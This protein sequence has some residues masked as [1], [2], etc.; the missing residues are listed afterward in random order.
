[1]NNFTFLKMK[2]V[3]TNHNLSQS[4][5]NMYHNTKLL[6]SK[7][8]DIVWSINISL[9]EMDEEC[10]YSV[11]VHSPLLFYLDSM[12][13]IDTRIDQARLKSRLSSL[14]DSKSI[15]D[16]INKSVNLIGKY[17]KKGK[18]YQNII[19]RAYIDVDEISMEFIAEELN[20]SRASFFR[21]KK[22]AINL[23]GSMLWGYITREYMKESEF[24]VD[25]LIMS[26]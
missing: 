9:D 8:R 12:V 4:K 11:H 2:Q 3:N 25:E 26:C 17:P 21:E 14:E 10:Q 15:I 5:E 22:K 16:L 19:L 20:M 24:T 13:E 18:L 23:L 7:Y 1:M 6:L